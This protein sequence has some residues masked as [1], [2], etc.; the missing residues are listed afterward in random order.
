MIKFSI[1][2][3]GSFLR[4]DFE[5]MYA[6]NRRDTYRDLRRAHRSLRIMLGD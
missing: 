1:L 5:C 3:G 6:A 4:T 2:R